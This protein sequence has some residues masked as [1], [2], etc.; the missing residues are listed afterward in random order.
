MLFSGHYIFRMARVEPPWCISGARHLRYL[1][2]SSLRHH[3]IDQSTV[4]KQKV[5]ILIQSTI[6]HLGK[7]KLMLHDME[8]MFHF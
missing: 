7:A 4:H 8:D 1:Q 6:A 3:Q 5:R 2:Q